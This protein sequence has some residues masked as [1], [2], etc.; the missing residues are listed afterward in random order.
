[1]RQHNRFLYYVVWTFIIIIFIAALITAL[2]ACVPADYDYSSK[3]IPTQKPTINSLGISGLEKLIDKEGIT[4]YQFR[5]DTSTSRITC[6][7][8]KYNNTGA[9]ALDCP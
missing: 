1:M 2:N 9:V 5:Q 6:I 8:A 4:I 7:V 3:S